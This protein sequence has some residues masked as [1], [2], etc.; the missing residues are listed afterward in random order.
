MSS[1]VKSIL[2]LHLSKSMITNEKTTSSKVE[3]FVQKTIKRKRS[4]FQT[5]QVEVKV[6]FTRF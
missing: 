4:G 5:T 6:F 1:G 2:K 3:R